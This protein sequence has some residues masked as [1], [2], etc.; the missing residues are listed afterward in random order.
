MIVL[1]VLG[2]VVVVC[3]V[4]VWAKVGLSRSERRSMESY[5]HALEVLG[6]V[7]RRSSASRRARGDLQRTTPPER[8]EEGG[9]AP[10][11]EPE[12]T[13]AIRRT[14][15]FEDDSVVYERWS[16]RRA[17]GAS[18]P[19]RAASASGPRR[20]ASARRPRRP[21][22]TSRPTGAAGAGRRRGDVDGSGPRLA[23]SWSRALAAGA[24]LVLIAAAVIAGL[25]L[26][27][28]PTSTANGH[29]HHPVTTNTVAHR[30]HRRSPSRSTTT[31]APNSISPVSTSPTVV[32]FV[33]PTGS[34]TL[35]FSATGSACWI[36]VQLTSGGPY[37]MQETL[38]PGQST[39]YSASGAVIV[40]VGAPKY[41]SMTVNG[42]A[43][44]LPPYPQPYDVTF[45]PQS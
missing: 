43:A 29:G 45:A 21:S 18:R 24:A 25:H 3:A 32:A 9:E 6:D 27:A 14:F 5:E 7:S 2:L 10:A 40:R 31:T 33:E 39:T 41:L 8:A 22:G 30:H 16:P 26:A 44:R 13:E 36:G 37:V 19:R 34:Y 12:P 23:I 15:R 11:D 35:D 42:L 4:S 1:I 20:A 28:S 17:P 38:D